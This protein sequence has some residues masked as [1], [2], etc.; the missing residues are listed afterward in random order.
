MGHEVYANGRAFAAKAGD[1]KVTAATPDVCLSPPSPPAGPAPVPYAVSSFDSDTT[2]GSKTVK[3]AGKEVM[4]KDKSSFKKCTGDEAATKGLGMGVITHNITGPVYFVAWSQDVEVEGENAVRHLDMTTSNHAS[5]EPGNDSVPMSEISEKKTPD[6]C[7]DAKA[8]SDAAMNELPEDMRPPKPKK[9][10]TVTTGKLT[11]PDG[12]SQIVKGCSQSI[13]GVTTAAAGWATGYMGELW[14]PGAIG[15]MGP[16]PSPLPVQSFVPGF[17]YLVAAKGSFFFRGGVILGPN[18]AEARIIEDIF[19]NGT[20]PPGSK[21]TLRVKWMKKNGE[22]RGFPCPSCCALIQAARAK[23]LEIVLCP[24]PGD[25][26]PD[27]S[28]GESACPPEK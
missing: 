15:G 12:T 13:P 21:L 6:D 5:N 10:I 26:P 23:G 22:V 2:D 20:P 7:D 27:E 17:L 8:A 3:I 19:K 9:A 16:Q 24:D 14:S 4:L 18:H 11:L 25:V 1:G 28:K